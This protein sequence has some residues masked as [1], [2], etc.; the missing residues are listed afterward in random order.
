MGRP[1]HYSAE[2]PARC[3]ALIGQLGPLVE[4]H[5]DPDGL[6]GGPLKTT[7]L[8]AMATPML[9][10]P[11]E[12]IFKPLIWDVVGVANDVAQD[13]DLDARF[14]E[15]LGKGRTF[16]AAPFYEAGVWRYVPDY[17]AFKVGHDWP[18][19]LLDG[20]AAEGAEATASDA[21][22]S[23]I[24]TGLR[25][26]LAHGG[27]TYLDSNGRHTQFATNMLGFASRVRQNDP[28]QLC[29]LR[30]TV[31]GFETFLRSWAKWLSAAGVTEELEAHGPG[32]FT[33]A[34]E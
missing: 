11:L 28:T 12:R 8:L 6:W 13:P 1:V 15:I 34:A 30:V 17:P 10:L 3:E 20:L 2:V 31:P 9:V 22:A 7:F 25:N 33:V 21:A 32:Y 4:E 18:D 27:V 16:G 19:D 5:S 26:A 14:A 29:L 24:L 23:K